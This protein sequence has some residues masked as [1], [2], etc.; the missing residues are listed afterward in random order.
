LTLIKRP[1]SSERTFDAIVVG[2]GIGGLTAAAALA[3]CGRRV[4]VLEQHTQLGGLTQT[5]KRDRYTFAT[6][7]HYIGGVGGAPGA[8]GQFGRMLGWLTGGRLEFASMGSPYDIVRLPGFE[9]PIEAPQSAYIARL[10]S[11][12]AGETA[13]ID[14]YFAACRD[15]QRAVITLMA[16]KAMPAPIAA[17]MRWLNAGRTRRALGSSAADAVRNFRDARL[18]AVLAARW[19]D[20]GLLPSQAPFAVH[21]LVT[22][23]YASGAFYPIGGPAQFARVLGETIRAAGGEL[24]TGAMVSEIRVREDR[25]AG[26]RLQSG[27]SIDATLVIS[28]A[29]AHNTVAALATDVAHDW[30]KAVESLKSGMSYVSLYLGFNGDIRAHGATPANVWVYETNDTDRLWERPADED[31]PGIFVSFP[32]LK[33]PSHEDPRQHTAEVVAFCAW[34]AFAPWAH[35]TF[36]HRPEEYQATKAWIAAQ[37]LA[38]FK[39]H[40][41]RL[42]PL[43]EFH[44]L[45]TPLSQ[46]VFV[47][48]NHGAAYG[49][50]MSSERMGTRVLNVR[51][52]IPGLLLAGQDV[53]GPGIQGAFM[54]GFMA[55]VATEPR[56]WKRMMQ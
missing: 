36:G 1:T 12:F 46:N 38:Q 42:A 50:E 4:L 53:T 10:K 39:R 17:V 31:A 19:G 6:G 40:F 5:F 35:S 7:L 21:A 45:S 32:S 11:V 51:T 47:H 13:A 49:L 37:L 22:G 24:R 44:E 55:A 8:E 27:E 18:A 16:A 30:R 15:A 28:A 34:D 3:K 43:I 20:Y 56:L 54:G 14:A 25:I 23:S 48:A 52:P 41:P 33:D 2:S 9:F 29:G 26:V